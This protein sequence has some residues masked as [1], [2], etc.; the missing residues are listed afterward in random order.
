MTPA[1]HAP[2]LTSDQIRLRLNPD[3]VMYA[4][5]HHLTTDG[6]IMNLMLVNLSEVTNRGIL[7][8]YG[9]AISLALAAYQT[10]LELYF[11]DHLYSGTTASPDYAIIIRFEIALWIAK[12]CKSA[13]KPY[14]YYANMIRNLDAAWEYMESTQITTLL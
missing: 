11:L 6:L 9:V 8:E 3:L 12:H 4:N 10:E 5:T 7:E 14:M 13:R 2:L 1:N